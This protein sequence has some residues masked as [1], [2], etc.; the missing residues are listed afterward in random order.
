MKPEKASIASRE[1]LIEENNLLEHHLAWLER[2]I[3]GTKSERFI[4]ANDQQTVLDL[5]VGASP[6]VPSLKQSVSYE[7]SVAKKRKRRTWQGSHAH[8]PAHHR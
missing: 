5:G 3:F 2:Q 8:A 7:R 1:E 6:A 4:P